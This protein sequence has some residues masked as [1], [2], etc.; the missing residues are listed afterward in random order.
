MVNPDDSPFQLA[1]KNDN[2]GA[3]SELMSLVANFLAQQAQQ[4]QQHQMNMHDAVVYDAPRS[5]CM[6]MCELCVAQPP[7]QEAGI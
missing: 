7:P 2:R 5:H 3:A 1:L 4:Q 6:H